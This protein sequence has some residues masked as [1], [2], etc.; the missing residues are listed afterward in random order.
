MQSIIK[1]DRS[2]PTKTGGEGGIGNEETR[3]NQ[4]AA[5]AARDSLSVTTPNSLH[6][7]RRESKPLSSLVV[8]SFLELTC[9]NLKHYPFYDAYYIIAG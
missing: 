7:R 1:I 8:V 2:R 5:S 6:C 4:N 3:T 9:R